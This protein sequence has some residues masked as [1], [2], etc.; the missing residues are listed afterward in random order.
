MV[1]VDANPAVLR[2]VQFPYT[3]PARELVLL[4]AQVPLIMPVVALR[5]DALLNVHAPVTAPAHV[6][7]VLKVQVPVTLAP[8]SFDD[9]ALKVVAPVTDAPLL[10]IDVLLNIVVPT[11]FP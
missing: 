3:V 11:T 9:A 4:K 2:N 1:P 10:L 8:A 7:D 6:A 5:T